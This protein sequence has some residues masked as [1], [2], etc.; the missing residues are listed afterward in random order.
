MRRGIDATWRDVTPAR[1]SEKAV[2][3]DVTKITTRSAATQSSL[4]FDEIISSSAVGAHAVENVV[5]HVYRQESEYQS[6]I[7][8]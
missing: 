3:F 4:E 2:P 7:G 5:S 8:L 6:Y 1:A